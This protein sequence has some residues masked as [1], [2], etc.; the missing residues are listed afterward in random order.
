M[1]SPRASLATALF[2][3]AGVLL[4]ACGENKAPERAGRPVELVEIVPLK[5]DDIV[6]VAGDVQA[7]TEVALGFRIGGRMTE[8]LVNV[9]DRVKGGQLVARLDPQTEQNALDAAEAAV[10]AAS[11]QVAKTR[12]T[13]DRQA[14][15]M[16]QGFTTRPRYDEARQALNTAEA[17]LDDAQAQLQ[18]AR[19]RVAFTELRADAGGVVTARGAEPGEVV[20]PGQ[21]IVRLAREDGKDAVFDVPARLLH[22]APDDPAV[23]VSL[24]DDPG[25]KATGRV[26]E[27]SPQADP[28]TR[29]F[30]VRV[31]LDAP[32]PAM[33]L[34]SSVSGRMAL[35]SDAVLSVP[36][37][38]LTM[39]GRSPAVFV[40]DPK[41]S[42]VAL[43]PVEMLR[44]GERDVVVSRGLEP[45]DLVVS[46]GVQALHPGQI[47]RSIARMPQRGPGEIGAGG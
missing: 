15:L 9:G 41:T 44:F 26:R 47:V 33:K 24:V 29:T 8:R 30:R 20:Q 31:G 5:L 11:G 28:V 1:M 4:A 32:P 39:T 27:V 10:V 43:R 45:G 16:E 40:Y 46:A 25:V 7:Q 17:A 6:Q 36:A 38:A 19:D 2:G 14:R 22:A 12:N 13:F 18:L 34:G 3:L 35:E 42:T 23:T 37:S 21:M